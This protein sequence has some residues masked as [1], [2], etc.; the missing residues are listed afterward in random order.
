VVSSPAQVLQAV[1]QEWGIQLGSITIGKIDATERIVALGPSA[2]A[3]L[4]EAFVGRD[5]LDWAEQVTCLATPAAHRQL[6]HAAIA[7]VDAHKPG[8]VV[9]SSEVLRLPPGARVVRSEDAAPEDVALLGS[10]LERKRG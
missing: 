5:D 7:V 1:A 3:T 9:S 4:A 6:A 8:R 2:I 10:S